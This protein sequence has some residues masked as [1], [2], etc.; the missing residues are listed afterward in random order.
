MSHVRISAQICQSIVSLLIWCSIRENAEVTLLSAELDTEHQMIYDTA[1]KLARDV[2]AGYVPIMEV[3]DRFPSEVWEHLAQAGFLGVGVSEEWGGTGGDYLAAALISQAIARVSPAIALSLGAHVNLCMHNIMRNGTDLLKQ[4]YVPSLASG[5][6]IGG[7][8]LTEPNAGSDALSMRMRAERLPN[9]YALTGT[10]TFITNGPIADL[11]V[12]YAVTQ[13]ER[14]GI[15][16]FVVETQESGFSVTKSLNKLGMRGSPTGELAFDH[17]FVPE[18]NVLGPVNGGV[19]VVM[20]GLDL[21]RAYYSA[22]AVGI[23]EEMLEQSVTYAKQREQFGQPIAQFELI[24][25]KLADMATHLDAARLLTLQ[26]LDLVEKG[27]RISRLAASALLF[28]AEAANRATNHALQ[29]HG[30]YGYTKDFPVERFFRDAKLLDIGAGTNE[31]RRIVI[32]RELLGD[33]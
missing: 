27:Q 15:T 2:L 22:T 16:A 32:A 13:Q 21:E 14:H 24:Q 17:V 5:R 4:K 3:Q 9:G 1:L 23:I 8:G 11:L 18:E 10:K 29:I 33:R 20:K 12:V 7:L 6:L 25:E 28:A 30:G 19:G 31:I 26:A